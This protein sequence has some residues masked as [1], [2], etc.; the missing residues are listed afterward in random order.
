VT[1][2]TTPTERKDWMIRADD[3]G[4]A[5]RDLNLAL[6]ENALLLIEQRQMR[7]ALPKIANFA[8]ALKNAGTHLESL[9]AMYE[10]AQATARKRAIE[11]AVEISVRESKAREAGYAEVLAF[12]QSGR[13]L[14][15]QAPNAKFAREIVKGW[16]AWGKDAAT[17]ARVFS[18]LTE[19]PPAPDNGHDALGLT[20]AS[21]V[22]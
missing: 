5:V 14:H 8:V 3:A 16:E 15:E 1:M 19:A 12:I 13:F 4:R 10:T 2:E 17:K 22:K 18:P 7:E 9:K 20:G 11:Y 6:A 21:P